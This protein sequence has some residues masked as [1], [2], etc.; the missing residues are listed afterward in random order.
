MGRGPPR[1]GRRSAAARCTAGGRGHAQRRG[2]AVL[3]A[4][5]GLDAGRT[6]AVAGGGRVVFAAGD[7]V[8]IRRNDYRS[9]RDLSQPDVLNGF[10]GVVLEV[11]DE[12][13]YGWN[14]AVDA[15]AVAGMSRRARGCRGR[16]SPRAG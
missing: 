2:R 12:R 10:R 3:V 5:G 16:T 9:R 6:Y 1:A 7:L 4:S 11:D 14:G 15:P 8:H 13:G